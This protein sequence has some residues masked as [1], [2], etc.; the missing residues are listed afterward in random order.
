MTSL[1]DSSPS[2]FKTEVIRVTDIEVLRQTKFDIYQ[3]L[4]I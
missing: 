4:S 2:R 1:I 3:Y